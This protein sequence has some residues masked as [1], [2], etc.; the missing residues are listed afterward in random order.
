MPTR[1]HDILRDWMAANPCPAADLTPAALMRGHES[2]DE[3]MR[4]MVQAADEQ[5]DEVDRLGRALRVAQ[6]D[7]DAA[8]KARDEARGVLD[9][10]GQVLDRIGVGPGLLADRVLALA[11]ERE[12]AREERNRARAQ[13]AAAE[14]RLENERGIVFIA[15]LLLCAVLTAAILFALGVLPTLSVA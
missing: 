3:G 15:V 5:I 9:G 4:R 6:G 13:L 8:R 2:L 12:Q 1:Y 14:M 11:C 10:A 7:R